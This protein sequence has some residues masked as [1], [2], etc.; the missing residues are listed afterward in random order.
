MLEVIVCDREEAV[1]PSGMRHVLNAHSIKNQARILGHSSPCRALDH[2][3]GHP[4]ER[5][6][7]WN[8]IQLLETR[9]AE[10]AG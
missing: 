10:F 1:L 5:L 7:W 6:S 2:F 4:Y 3:P 8:R 9:I